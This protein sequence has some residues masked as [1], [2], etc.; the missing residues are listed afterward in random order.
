MADAI[1]NDAILSAMGST[2]SAVGDTIYIKGALTEVSTTDAGL[3][4][5]QGFG[6]A[7]PADGDINLDGVV[8]VADVLPGTQ[9]L[10]GVTTLTSSQLLHGDVAPLVGSIPA[11]DGFFTP[12][13]LMVIQRKVLGQINF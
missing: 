10:S 13:D 2:A 3:L 11:P 9:A 7:P 4:V 12:G 5:T 6:A 8:N 1:N